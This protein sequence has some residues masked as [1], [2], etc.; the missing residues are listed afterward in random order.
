[1]YVVFMMV[2]GLG[3]WFYCWSISGVSVLMS[4]IYGKTIVY[5]MHLKMD[6]MNVFAIFLH[7]WVCVCLM[8][9][10]DAKRKEEFRIFSNYFHFAWDCNIMFNIW[11]VFNLFLFFIIAYFNH[12]KECVLMR[13]VIYVCSHIESLFTPY[14]LCLLMCLY[15]ILFIVFLTIICFAL[16]VSAILYGFCDFSKPLKWCYFKLAFSILFSYDF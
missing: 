12:I 5:G 2:N 6:F 1:M 4:D 3:F 15:L 16:F 7:V 14:Q 11:Y 9:K 13:V 10:E 8:N